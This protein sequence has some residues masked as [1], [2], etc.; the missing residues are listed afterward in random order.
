VINRRRLR[1]PVRMMDAFSSKIRRK[2]SIE[3]TT[4]MILSPIVAQWHLNDY[5]RWS[6]FPLVCPE[7]SAPLGSFLPRA[8][9]IRI[10]FSKENIG[11]VVYILCNHSRFPFLLWSDPPFIVGFRQ[12]VRELS[13][14]VPCLLV[15]FMSCFTSSACTQVTDGAVCPAKQQPNEP[16][17]SFHFG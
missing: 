4:W 5:C 17:H 9:P 15:S 12:A 2:F 3:R 13:A 7:C 8:P 1:L 6:R 14:A 10:F 11:H 16:T